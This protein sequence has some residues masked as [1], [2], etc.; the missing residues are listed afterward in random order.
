MPLSLPLSQDPASSGTVQGAFLEC[1]VPAPRGWAWGA[2]P[3]LGAALALPQGGWGPQGSTAPVPAVT[4]RTPTTLQ[5]PCSQGCQNG[6]FP[7]TQR[8]SVLPVSL[9]CGRP[10]APC[11]PEPMALETGNATV[12]GASTD[13]GQAFG[14][15]SS[16]ASAQR[17]L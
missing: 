4:P 2:F 15:P 1:Q 13:N 12:H 3:G 17:R 9:A 8:L 10:L 5:K 16:R 6:R 11:A 14:F 7:G